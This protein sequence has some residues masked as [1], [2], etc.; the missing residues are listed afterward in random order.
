MSRSLEA[1]L[2]PR[3]EDTG[4]TSEAGQSTASC[5]LD[6][7]MM[8]DRPLSIPLKLNRFLPLGSCP[9]VRVLPTV[10]VVEYSPASGVCPVAWSQTCVRI[11]ECVYYS[12][13]RTMSCVSGMSRVRVA[14][15]CPAAE[16]CPA[17]WRQMSV[18][19]QG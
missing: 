18:H 16:V 2:C 10:Q 14:E 12:D 15:L 8:M 1:E 13:S 6:L 5:I 3:G 7:P 19:Q 4:Y 9:G 17:T 11:Q